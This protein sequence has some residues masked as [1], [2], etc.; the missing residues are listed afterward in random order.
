MFNFKANMIDILL[1][2]LLIYINLLTLCYWEDFGGGCDGG[3]G[4]TEGDGLLSFIFTS[5]KTRTTEWHSSVA[6][7]VCLLSDQNSVRKAE[8]LMSVVGFII[9]N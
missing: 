9:G 5:S 3:A 2:Y 8:S 6:F 4:C 7:T 1:F